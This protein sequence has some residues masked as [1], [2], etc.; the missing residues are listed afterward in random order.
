MTPFIEFAFEFFTSNIWTQGS[1][2]WTQVVE[3]DS[4]IYPSVTSFKIILLDRMTHL[5]L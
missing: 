4:F 3:N 2:L 1:N 5:Y